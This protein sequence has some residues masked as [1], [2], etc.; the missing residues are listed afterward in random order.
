MKSKKTVL[1]IGGATQDIYVRFHG[2]DSM[3][4][5]KS[6]GELSYMLFESGAKIEVEDL[7][8]FSG[9]GATNSAVTFSR[10]DCETTCFCIVSDDE[11]G[12]HVLKDLKAEN[13]NTENIVTTKDQPTGRSFVVNSVNG[14]R[15][16]FA[17][18]GANRFLKKE[19]VPLKAIQ[20][21]DH[22]Y[23]TSLS[24]EASQLLPEIVSV[25]KKNKKPVAINP[26]VSQ[27]STG[28]SVLRDSLKDIDILIL[29]SSEA[30]TFMAALVEKGDG[31]KDVFKKGKVSDEKTSL[32]YQPISNENVSFCLKTFFLEIFKMGPK[33][34]VVTDSSKGVYVATP[35]KI[36]FHPSLETKVVDTLGAGDAFGSC[37]VASIIRGEKEEKALC[38]GMINAV[39]VIGSF[40]AKPGIL[41]KKEL[42][43]KSAA[44]SLELLQT[45]SF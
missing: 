35:E 2:A 33:Y 28:A 13:I 17:H 27:L 22:I 6:S 25:A 30:R 11:A 26:G 20:S 16:I 38:N 21:V 1:T 40:G 10:Q 23:I 31:Y 32:L 3:K 42:E 12:A 24:L 14:E 44:V 45:F 37:F 43:E 18:R 29:N 9:G 8:Y 15:T 34:V 4:I 41:T 5:S 39:S 19:Y 36:L 7:S